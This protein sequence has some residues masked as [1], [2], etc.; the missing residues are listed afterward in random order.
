MIQTA[1]SMIVV[2]SHY[3]RNAS[4]LNCSY[5]LKPRTT[6][7]GVQWRWALGIGVGVAVLTF[8]LLYLTVNI[9]AAV[10]SIASRGSVDYAGL[11]RFAAI[12]GVWGLPV[13]YL[14]IVTG[15]T[16][17]WVRSAAVVSTWNGVVVGLISAVG[18]QIV[19]L[20]FGPPIV[21]ELIAYPLLGVAGGWLGSMIG[22]LTLAGRES[23]YRASSAISAA[24]DP[25]FIAAA[26]GE[27]LASAEV[28]RITLWSITS[29]V[30]DAGPL[31]LEVVGSWSRRAVG[32]GD[33]GSSLDSARMPALTSLRRQSPRTVRRHE[34][35]PSEREAWERRGVRSALL[36]PLGA[37]GDGPDGLLMVTSRKL[38][39]FSRGT[40]RAYQT[41]GVQAALA[42]EN[43]RLVEQA[44]QSGVLVERQRL[45][46]EIHD[47]LIQGFA[48]IVMNLEA[49]EGSLGPSESRGQRHLDQARRT[50]RESLTEARRIV[51]ALRPEVLE[52]ATLS[53][54]LTRLAGR[55]SQ[56]S[57]VTAAVSVTGPQQPLSPETEVTLLRA[58]QEALNNVRKH[59]G[60]RRV[61]LTLSY[62]EDRVALDIQDDGVG[63]EPDGRGA[64]SSEQNP[65]GFGLRAMR[66]RIEQ[67]GGTL[68]VESEPGKGTTLAVELPVTSGWSR[69]RVAEILEGKTP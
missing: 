10:L 68:V 56:G 64:L 43:L 15:A 44:R 38:L 60:A 32:A 63:F 62:M 28:E 5:V 51:W 46:R 40:V 34:L 39:A 17:L 19:G 2:F 66:E 1:K 50:A 57:G 59:A 67:S 29:C 4:G 18:L 26:I 24:D 7:S 54:A 23:M 45:A 22:R 30:G 49:A 20:A 16:A 6:L 65:G 55:W 25:Q 27:H 33:H 36:I 61:M 48:S 69:E 52:D 11:N 21:S 53:E 3:S 13:L 9:Y 41:A 58:A 47:T 35:S 14:L 42:L 37:S 12:M 31:E 8:T